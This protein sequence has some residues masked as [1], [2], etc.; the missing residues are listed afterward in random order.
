MILLSEP[1]E[2]VGLERRVLFLFSCRKE[3]MYKKVVKCFQKK[4]T[5]EGM[6]NVKSQ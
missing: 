4:K 2:R 1:E 6:G 3:G 5:W